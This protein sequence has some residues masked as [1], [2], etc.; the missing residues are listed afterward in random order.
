MCLISDSFRLIVISRPVATDIQ[1]RRALPAT[2]N[3]RLALWRHPFGTRVLKLPAG[4]RGGSVHTNKE[5][6]GCDV[7]WAH[8]RA[9]V[10]KSYCPI[11][12]DRLSDWLPLFCAPPYQP[13][14]TGQ[15]QPPAVDER[16]E[17][18]ALEQAEADCAVP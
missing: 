10:R 14:A 15:S 17:A 4:T 16:R 9:P 11:R 18:R 7:Y 13:D 3:L 1:P 8:C 12:N 6:A 5:H 2:L